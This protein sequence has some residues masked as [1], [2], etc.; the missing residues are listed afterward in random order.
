VDAVKTKFKKEYGGCTLVSVTYDETESELGAERYIRSGGGQ[1]KGVKAENVIYLVSDFKTGEKIE[2]TG[3]E[4]NTEYDG[5]TWTVVR[6]S[7]E[8]WYV[9]D[10]GYC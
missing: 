9:T 6:E 8:K 2:A 4:T 10:W 1:E 7:N 5:W 3:F